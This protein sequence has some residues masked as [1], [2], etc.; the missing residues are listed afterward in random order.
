VSGELL[1]IIVVALVILSALA[2]IWMGMNSRRQIREMEHRERLAMIERG[3]L[4]PPEIDPEAFEHRFRRTRAETQGSVRFRSAG[5]MMIGLGLAF[6]F[7]V[8]FAGGAT[9]AGVGIG[10]A[11]AILG[12]AFLANALM[13]SRSQQYLPPPAPTHRSPASA[14]PPP[15]PPRQHESE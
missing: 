4:P 15:P 8:S 10:L 1:S 9:G 14:P 13:L 12:A 6:M 11:F 2:V 7:L 5:I 3:L